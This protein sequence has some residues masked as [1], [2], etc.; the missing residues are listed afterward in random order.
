MAAPTIR[1]ASA[2]RRRI[3][4][5]PDSA[6]GCC[7]LPRRTL[8]GFPRM[9]KRSESKFMRETIPHYPTADQSGIF[10]SNRPRYFSA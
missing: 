5:L 10:P 1:I 8:E 2:R 7:P 3:A 9:G 4:R 6:A